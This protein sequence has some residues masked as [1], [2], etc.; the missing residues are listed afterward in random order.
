MPRAPRKTAATPAP[1][2]TAPAEPLPREVASDVGVVDTKEHP[3]PDYSHVEG[4]PDGIILAP[5]EPLR[6]EGDDDGTAVTVT[7]DVYRVV[8]PLGARRPTY[9]L[10]YPRGRMVPKSLLQSAD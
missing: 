8:Y 3:Q 1:V 6:L 4:V 2:D 5:G 9:V 7:R 10:L